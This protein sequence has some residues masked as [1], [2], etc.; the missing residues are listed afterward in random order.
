M[1][2]SIRLISDLK[3]HVLDIDEIKCKCWHCGHIQLS[4]YTK[5]LLT[6]KK[7]FGK[8]SNRVG[9]CQKCTYPLNENN[10]YESKPIKINCKWCN[11][12]K[13]NLSKQV[14][15]KDYVILGDTN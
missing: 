9:S 6:G 5:Q 11:P 4:D 8:I 3:Y 14:P 2:I 10:F 15:I 12:K 13:L 1:K 7:I